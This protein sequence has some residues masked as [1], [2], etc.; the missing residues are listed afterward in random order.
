MEFDLTWLQV[1]L[2]ALAENM[3]RVRER[4]KTDVLAVVK[5]DAY[6]LGAVTV[7]RALENDCAFLGTANISEALELRRGGIGKPILILGRVPV[8]AYPFAVAE[9]IRVPIFIYEDALALSEEAVRQGKTAN[10]HFVVDTGMSR[11]G[12]QATEESADMCAQICQ[13]PNLR[14]EGLFSH[15]ATADGADLTSA[16]EQLQLFEEFTEKLKKRGIQIPIRHLNNSAGIINFPGKQDMVRSGIVQYGMYPSD[17]VDQELLPVR[18]VMEWIAKVVYVKTLPAGRQISYGGC[19]TTTRETKVATLPVGY[20]D[21]YRRSLTD[22]GH[23]LIR[24]KKAPIIGRICMDQMMVDVTDIPGVQIGD[25][26]VLIGRSGDE[27]ITVDYLA[28]L[29]GTLN[30]EIICGIS[31][32]TPRVYLRGGKRV[33]EVHYLLDTQEK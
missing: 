13:L 29:T 5:A 17:E 22:K 12:F 19:Y 7:A 1:D 25:H 14:A 26:A 11:I 32:R 16:K 31:R 4:A 2:D 33:S 10:F 24:G 9:D 8:Y 23:V 28:Q 21:G 6:G 3:H 15:Y 20:A 18:P 30:Y 27:Q